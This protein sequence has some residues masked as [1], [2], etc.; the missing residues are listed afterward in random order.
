[1]EQKVSQEQEQKQTGTLVIETQRDILLN[2]FQLAGLQSEEAHFKV[3]GENRISIAALDPSYVSMLVA[4][5]KND[6]RWGWIKIRNTGNVQKFAVKTDDMIKLLKQFRKNDDLI[7]TIDES[8]NRISIDNGTTHSKLCLIESSYPH[9]IPYIRFGSDVEFNI[10]VDEFARAIDTVAKMSNKVVIGVGSGVELEN[11]GL[12]SGYYYGYGY[13]PRSKI[14]FEGE[15]YKSEVKVSIDAITD[16]VSEMPVKS[17][18][19]VEYLQK[20]LKILKQ[21]VH[22]QLSVKFGR[23]LPIII[24][25]REGYRS[26]LIDVK[27]YLAPRVSD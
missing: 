12:P 10:D 9:T 13:R 16:L 20:I 19:G 5:L 7:M 25:T 8:E 27:F 3:D 18:Y 22:E 26:K 4:S 2:L 23:N 24:S 21:I 11:D 1:M 17:G 14:T 15:E 6:R